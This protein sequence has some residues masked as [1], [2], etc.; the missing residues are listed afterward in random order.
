MKTRSHCPA[1]KGVRD[2]DQAHPLMVRH[3]GAYDGNAFALRQTPRRVVQG[4]IPT[5]AA[6]PAR[7][8]QTAEI[9]HRGGWLDHGCERRRI[10]R[11]DDVLAEPSLE[12]ES[13]DTKI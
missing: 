1:A 6:T 12:A 4:L 13:R 2:S 7:V 11:N 9:P 10:G 8:G 5:V 3:I